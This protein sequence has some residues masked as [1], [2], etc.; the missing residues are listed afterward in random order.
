[1]GAAYTYGRDLWDCLSSL[2]ESTTQRTFFMKALRSF[3]SSYKKSLDVF[4][5]SL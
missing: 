4:S 1:M 3:F 5:Q 2:N